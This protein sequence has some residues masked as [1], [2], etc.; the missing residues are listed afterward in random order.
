MTK[1]VKIVL[2]ITILFLSICTAWLLTQSIEG[3]YIS[4]GDTYLME[5]CQGYTCFH[6]GKVY[7]VNISDNIGDDAFYVGTYS[8]VS[9]RTYKVSCKIMDLEYEVFLGFSKIS[10]GESYTN[11][12]NGMPT[13]SFNGIKE[14]YPS[15]N[16]RIKKAISTAR[17]I[18]K[19]NN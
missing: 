16:S 8:K 17:V 11:R 10:W 3:N 12:L 18:K 14:F 5:V 1:K 9:N 15:I 2:I 4:T 7:S 6:N 19:T 13:Q